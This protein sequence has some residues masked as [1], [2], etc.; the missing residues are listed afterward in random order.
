MLGRN[1]LAKW[2]KLNSAHIDLPR[3]AMYSTDKSNPAAFDDDLEPEDDSQKCESIEDQAK[4]WDNIKVVKLP[5]MISR[6]SECKGCFSK[7]VCSLA[8]ISLEADIPRKPPTGQFQG[9]QDIQQK[10]TPQIR[11]YF[12]RYIECINLEQSAE[13]DRQSSSYNTTINKETDLNMLRM[14]PN[15]GGGVI[16]TLQK[17]ILDTKTSELGERTFVN[18]YTH[19]NISFGKG[20]I[21]SRQYYFKP[22]DSKDLDVCDEPDQP[23]PEDDNE[24]VAST[25]IRQ[26]QVDKAKL[27]NGTYKTK[28]KELQ[29]NFQQFIEYL[30]EFTS[31]M[32]NNLSPTALGGT[33]AQDLIWTLELEPFSTF[34]YSVMRNN[35]FSL[36]IMDDFQKMRESIIYQKEPVKPSVES[37]NELARRFE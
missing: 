26:A 3:R 25:A 13:L 36:C 20:F 10:A 30:V 9:F 4:Q 7:E 23:K 31:L 1:E 11:Q 28:S 37:I 33:K 15:G 29:K 32:P 8:A 6:V 5:P 19:N 35:I 27:A 14:N 18:L 24:P 16:V 34:S 17:P 21:I 22:I 12:K 2:Q